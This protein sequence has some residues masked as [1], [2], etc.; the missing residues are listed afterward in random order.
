MAQ[1]NILVQD[2]DF[3]VVLER[4]AGYKC[5]SILLSYI[6][7]PSNYNVYKTLMPINT[8]ITLYKISSQSWPKFEFTVFY[9]GIYI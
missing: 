4:Q 1:F 7:R 3:P 8:F 6:N 5:L 2:H 9:L